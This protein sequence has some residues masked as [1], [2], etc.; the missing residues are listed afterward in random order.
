MSAGDWYL[1]I[2]LLAAAGTTLSLV[3]ISRPP[4]MLIIPLFVISLLTSELTWFMVAAQALVSAIFIAFG[5][6]GD[7]SGKLA[8][9]VM[10]ASWAGMLRLHVLSTRADEMLRRGLDAGLGANYLDQIPAP[11]RA[12][13]RSGI[14][15]RQCRRPFS[16]RNPQ[17]ERLTD[18]SYGDAGERNLLDIYRPVSGREG[19]CPILLQI[20]GGGWFIGHKQEQA[21]PLMYHL[22][23]RGWLCVSINYRL[24]PAHT[25]PAH[26]VDVKKA[27]AWIKTHIMQY[28]GD[29]NFIAVTGGSAGGHLSALAALSA[30]DPAYQPGFEA[31]DTRVDAAV[32]VYGVYDFLDHSGLDSNVALRQF[33]ADKIMGGPPEQDLELW[34]QASPV[35]RVRSDAPPFFVIHGG[36][37]V[38][39]APAEARIFSD[40]LHGISSQA[41]A[42]A[43]LPGAQHAF[44]VMQSV[45]TGYMVN[46][47]HGFLEWAYAHRS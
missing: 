16:F 7:S 47:V 28:G 43:E 45:R 42:Y 22:A 44:D 2:A 38:M 32:P 9:L 23:E 6:L 25:F 46:H 39:T 11:R 21:L 37:D 18:I 29:P 8:L 19:G 5:A 10:A 3:K 1:V 33:L 14:D 26:I 27:I 17:V 4:S 13:L 35:E 41:V 36:N 31:A 12:L 40:K 30:N 20:H 15:G 34:R 24:S